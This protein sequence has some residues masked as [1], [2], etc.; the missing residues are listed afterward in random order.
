MKRETIFKEGLNLAVKISGVRE[1][2]ILSRKRK[3]YIVDARKLIVYFMREKYNL[4]W[5]E[6]AKMFDMNHSSIIHMYNSFLSDSKYDKRVK[7]C[8]V[9][10]DNLVDTTKWWKL[11]VW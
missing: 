7:S 4:R 11:I 10:V 5:T 1:R 3:R 6:M 8:R 9:E 2:E